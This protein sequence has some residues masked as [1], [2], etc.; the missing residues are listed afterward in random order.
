MSLIVEIATICSSL[1]AVFSVVA[2][3][4]RQLVVIKRYEEGQRC[5]LRQT[6]LDTYYHCR[7]KSEIRQYAYENFVHLYEAYKA[8]GGNSFIDK[9]YDEVKEWEVIT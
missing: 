3:A 5:L 7:D 9:I 2:I 4:R 6:M 8:M 1:T